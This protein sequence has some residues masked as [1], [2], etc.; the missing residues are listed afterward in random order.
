[1]VSGNVKSD[2]MVTI[3]LFAPK[4]LAVILFLPFY[5][6]V[7]FSVYTQ[8]HSFIHETLLVMSLSPRVTLQRNNMHKQS[9]NRLTAAN[10]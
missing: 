9:V 6:P 5:S 3:A 7:K 10:S 8:T 1:M 2:S 4:L